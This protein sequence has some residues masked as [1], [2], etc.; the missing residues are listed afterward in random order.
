MCS[1]NLKELE[2]KNEQ[3]LEKILAIYD[4]QIELEELKNKRYLQQRIDYLTNKIS[5]LE[6]QS[7]MSKILLGSFG[8]TK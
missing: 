1:D 2:L 8:G 5:E 6:F 4:K 7:N 3:H